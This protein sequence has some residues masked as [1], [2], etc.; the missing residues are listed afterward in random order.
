MFL[1]IVVVLEKQP[2]DKKKTT[3]KLYIAFIFKTSLIKTSFLLAVIFEEQIKI[4][5]ITI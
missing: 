1:E 4:I 3:D 5:L 2:V